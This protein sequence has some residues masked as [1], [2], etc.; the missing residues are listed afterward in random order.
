MNKIN[1]YGYA[2]F[3]NGNIPL[4]IVEIRHSMLASFCV[5]SNAKDAREHIVKEKNS[6]SKY[7]P[8]EYDSDFSFSSGL[9]CMYTDANKYS[10]FSLLENRQMY[11]SRV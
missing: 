10:L 2:V 4:H 7:A 6:L 11:I 1:T 3:A 5:F 9:I 8:L